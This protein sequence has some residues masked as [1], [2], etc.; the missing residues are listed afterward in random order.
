MHRLILSYLSIY[1]FIVFAS[2]AFSETAYFL[3]MYGSLRASRT[4]NKLLVNSVL[5]ST[6]RQVSCLSLGFFKIDNLLRWL[7]VTPIARIIS[8]CTQDIGTIDDPLAEALGIVFSVTV[9]LI[10]K[11]GA[12]L[13]FTPLFL[14]PGIALGALG[15][16]L[17]TLFIKAQ[18]SVKREMR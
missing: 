5:T 7:D 3:F 1:A 12:V 11:L 10:T 4:I 2:F 13:I 17:G 6:F 9:G 8:R 15:F 18:L 14:L 16:Y